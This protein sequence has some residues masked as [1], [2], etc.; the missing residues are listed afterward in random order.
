MNARQIGCALVLLL[1]VFFQSSS[2][3]GAASLERAM[4]VAV[5]I[6]TNQGTSDLEIVANK[7]NFLI[8]YDVSTQQFT[9]LNIPFKVRS[10]SGSVV[11][12]GLKVSTLSGLCDDG[13]PLVPAPELDGQTVEVNTQY[14][15]TGAENNH[16][17]T[18]SF[19]YLSQINVAQQCEGFVGVVAGLTI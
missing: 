6:V 3:V 8:A 2:T 5:N 13:S 4:P 1:V 16:V 12:Y 9:P 18:L 17:L 10:V 19:P 7:I 11:D 14:A 15:F